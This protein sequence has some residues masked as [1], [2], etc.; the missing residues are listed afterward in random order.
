MTPAR[1][2]EDIQE[3]LNHINFLADQAGVELDDEDRQ[4][5]Y[6]QAEARGFTGDATEALFEETYPSVDEDELDWDEDDFDDDGFAG[7]GFEDDEDDGVS[8]HLM[9]DLELQLRNLE[10]QRGRGLTDHEVAAVTETSG[11]QLRAGQRLDVAGALSDYEDQFAT[12]QKRAE[13]FQRR[14]EESKPDV[15]VRDEYDMSTGEGRKAYYE[16]R[17][18]GGVPAD[19]FGW[20]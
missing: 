17:I 5:L 6:H 14:A 19:D 13:F 7:E 12:P 20:E 1:S 15:E 18:E 16:A 3:F 9:S 2:E 11:L 10:Q 8:E 4:E